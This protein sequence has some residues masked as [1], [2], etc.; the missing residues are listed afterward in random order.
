MI[1][2]F[3]LCTL[4]YET[5]KWN[6]KRSN[7]FPKQI[8]YIKKV[9]F[10]LSYIFFLQTDVSEKLVNRTFTESPRIYLSR[11]NLRTYMRP[12]V[13]QWKVLK[14]IRSERI[15]KKLKIHLGRN[16]FNLHSIISSASLR[17]YSICVNNACRMTELKRQ[18]SFNL[19]KCA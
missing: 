15:E 16:I 12:S 10:D 7:L 19:R 11:S 6:K 8:R 17:I 4:S 18:M 2:I 3:F 1:L 5:S 9:T 14:P 13:A